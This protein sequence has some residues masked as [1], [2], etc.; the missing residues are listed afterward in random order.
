MAYSACHPSPFQGYH[1]SN[2]FIA[3]QGEYP[4][5]CVRAPV[6]VYICVMTLS[7]LLK[8]TNVAK[9][10]PFTPKIPLDTPPENLAQPASVMVF[11]S[12]FLLTQTILKWF[13]IVLNCCFPCCAAFPVTLLTAESL[14]I[15]AG[16]CEEGH[17]DA[18]FNS[19]TSL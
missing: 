3:T 1:R 10:H 9:G 6:C 7:L 14:E 16:P 5:M 15:S 11:V 4:S 17:C 8:T 19:S 13:I 2:H 12:F 18:Q